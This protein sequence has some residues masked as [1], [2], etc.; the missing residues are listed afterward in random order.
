MGRVNRGDIRNYTFKAP[1]KKR[2]VLVLSRDSAIGYLNEITIAPITSTIRGIPS[3]VVLTTLDGMAK[4]C[5]VS[6]D[7]I[8]TVP[9][10]RVGRLITTL[11]SEKMNA[12]KRAAR[13]LQRFTGLCRQ[14]RTGDP[15]TAGSGFGCCLQQGLK[16]IE[17]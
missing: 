10:N 15:P 9:N 1:H 5:A 6:L 2:P 17:P 4:E 8:Q 14:V 13:H 7:H 12:V 3:E 16:I 11:G